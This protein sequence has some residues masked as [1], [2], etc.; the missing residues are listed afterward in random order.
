MYSNAQNQKFQITMNKGIIYVPILS[1]ATWV[2]F[3]WLF[4]LIQFSCHLFGVTILNNKNQNNNIESKKKHGE[5][6]FIHSS[7][8]DFFYIGENTF[9]NKKF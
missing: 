7:H 3:L 2:L 5:Q 8:N 6:A 4:S 9:G 1:L